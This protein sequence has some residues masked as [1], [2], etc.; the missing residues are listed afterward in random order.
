MDAGLAGGVGTPQ[1]GGRHGQIPSDGDRTVP[2]NLG[3][4]VG[5]VPKVRSAMRWAPD[6]IIFVA[7]DLLHLDG[8]N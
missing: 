4:R 8:V 7:F 2:T 6:R 3:T 5:L 1:D